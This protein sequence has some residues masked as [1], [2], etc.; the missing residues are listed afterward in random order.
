MTEEI[1]HV[2]FYH[3][4]ATRIMRARVPLVLTNVDPTL[5][6]YQKRIM[7]LLPALE[8]ETLPADLPTQILVDAS[9]LTEIDDDV[10]VS[11]LVVTDKV[12]V[13]VAVETL[14]AKVAPI[15]IRVL[16]EEEEAAAVAEGEEG[17]VAEGE[18]AP[19]EDGKP[20]S[21]EAASD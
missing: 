9:A 6:Q 21:G 14:V 7:Q 3:V 13:L 1:L 18:A 17:A 12:T 8:I 2:D 4:E 19:G 11:D 15:V 5:E 16:D 10:K 20:E